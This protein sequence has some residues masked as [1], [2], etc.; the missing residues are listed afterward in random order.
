MHH[1]DEDNFRQFL[2]SYFTLV[3]RT[4][5]KLKRAVS[6]EKCI[7][8]TFV[9]TYYISGSLRFVLQID[10]FGPEFALRKE[11][12]GNIKAAAS[13]LMIV[14]FY[15]LDA[16]ILYFS[17]LILLFLMFRALLCLFSG[18][19]IVLVLV[20]SLSLGVCSVHRYLIL[21]GT[22]NKT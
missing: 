14:F 8:E 3:R 19:Q 4:F 13:G 11:Q 10:I 9:V 12:C 6:K 1:T 5:N 20:S 15:Q 17:T 7:K 22:I 2:I 18:G 21:E 16:Q